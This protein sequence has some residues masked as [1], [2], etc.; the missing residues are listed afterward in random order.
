MIATFSSAADMILSRHKNFRDGLLKVIEP[1]AGSCFID[2]RVGRNPCD[3]QVTLMC[4]AYDP[5][6]VPY[7]EFKVAS[8]LARIA[9]TWSSEP[10]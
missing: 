5:I 9:R 6:V 4:Q 10:E 2:G 1:L 8:T 7:E 3:D